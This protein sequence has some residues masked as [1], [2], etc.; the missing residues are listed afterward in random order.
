[1]AG[2]DCLLI[3]NSEKLEFGLAMPRS[4]GASCWRLIST[5]KVDGVT[6]SAAHSWRLKLAYVRGMWVAG[7]AALVQ[8]TKRGRMGIQYGVVGV[9]LRPA[10][11]GHSIG[12]RG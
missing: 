4:Y 9:E 3:G 7:G 8:E 2:Q 11:G 6:L 1:M 10:K 12:G 5:P